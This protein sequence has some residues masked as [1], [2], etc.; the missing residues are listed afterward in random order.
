MMKMYTRILFLCFFACTYIGA[1]SAQNPSDSLLQ[2]IEA[3]A[4]PEKRLLKRIKALEDWVVSDPALA[5]K[6]L[7]IAQPQAKKLGRIADRNWLM[8]LAADVQLSKGNLLAADSLIKLAIQACPDS[9]ANCPPDVIAHF[10]NLQGTIHFRLSDYVA[11]GKAFQ[12][13]GEWYERSGAPE[14]A[15]CS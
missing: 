1:I 9:S 5:E 4:D 13:T 10:Y 8:G 15:V 2:V 12:L 6:Q 7:A 11:A 3:E 14:R